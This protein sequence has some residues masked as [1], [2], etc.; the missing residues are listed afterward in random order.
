MA[1]VAR[2]KVK[3]ISVRVG[4]EGVIWLG[5]S[6]LKA[7]KEDGK[8]IATFVKH[9]FSERNLPDSWMLGG[10]PQQRLLSRDG[11][12]L[13]GGGHGATAR[14]WV[15]RPLAVELL[16]AAKCIASLVN[17]LLAADELA[18]LVPGKQVDR[19]CSCCPR[20][21]NGTLPPVPTLARAVPPPR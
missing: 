3:G 8:K 11:A 9:K 21:D 18:A 14:T 7:T 12:L 20:L 13:E 17:L 19:F 15:T 4:P 6:S 5:R 16:M 2:G 1:Y 10:R